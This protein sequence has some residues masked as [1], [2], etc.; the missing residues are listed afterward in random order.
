MLRFVGNFSGSTWIVSENLG[1][2]YGKNRKKTLFLNLDKMC[3]DMGYNELEIELRKTLGQ[4]AR[5]REMGYMPTIEQGI[6]LGRLQK[7]Y[8]GLMDLPCSESEE[9]SE[10]AVGGK[11]AVWDPQADHEVAAAE[12]VRENEISRASDGYGDGMAPDDESFEPCCDPDVPAAESAVQGKADDDGNFADMA[13][14]EGRRASDEAH[15]SQEVGEQDPCPSQSRPLS[16]REVPEAEKPAGGEAEPSEETHLMQEYGSRDVFPPVTEVPEADKKLV[17]EPKPETPT[18]FGIEV[19]P[20]A[21]HEII[22]T[23]FHGN[24]E[25]FNAECG[26]LDAMGS[27]EEALVYIGETYRW[28][29]ENAATIKFIDLLETR[30]GEQA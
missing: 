2:V 19:S 9:Q 6:A 11:A 7:I 18:I 15:L 14:E 4:I 23:L 28:I 26:K 8:A 16:E 27:L 21:R 12:A 13:V 17:G 3:S 25:L 5:W 30:F 20:Y 1:M 10:R 24:L 29:P 22:D